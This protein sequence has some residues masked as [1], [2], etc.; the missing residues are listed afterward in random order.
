MEFEWNEL[1]NQQNIIKHGIGFEEAK[2]IFDDKYLTFIDNRVDYKETREISIGIIKK[3]VVVVVVHTDRA[4]K[5]RIISARKANSKERE[6]Y[7]E[8]YKY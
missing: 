3:L 5:V 4:G 6:K 7:N 1:K 8:R 2:L